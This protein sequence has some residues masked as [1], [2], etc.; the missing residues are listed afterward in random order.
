MDL[1]QIKREQEDLKRI[2]TS[3]YIT[4]RAQRLLEDAAVMAGVSGSKLVER[5]IEE[6]LQ[7]R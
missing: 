1:E 6:H 2:K 5:L 4:R 7:T 3:I